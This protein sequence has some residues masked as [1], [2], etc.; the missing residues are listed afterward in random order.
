MA[1]TNRSDVPTVI[2]DD[3]HIVYRVNTGGGGKGSAK[4]G[5]AHV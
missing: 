4:I 1:D 5:R 3:V 2:C